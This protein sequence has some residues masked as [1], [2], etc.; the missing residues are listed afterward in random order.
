MYTK[1]HGYLRNMAK[2]GQIKLLE[3]HP[4]LELKNRTT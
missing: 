2:T 1:K 4:K 3:P